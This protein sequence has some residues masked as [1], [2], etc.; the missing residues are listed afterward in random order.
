MDF[1]SKDKNSETIFLLFY[2]A[3]IVLEIFK[4]LCRYLRILFLIIRIISDYAA[5]I[6]GVGCRCRFYIAV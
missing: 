4:E 3:D 2:A 5:D 6:A 1:S